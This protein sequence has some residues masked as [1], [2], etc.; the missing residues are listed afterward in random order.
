[1]SGLYTPVDNMPHWAQVLSYFSPLKYVIQVF[2]MIYLKG[3]GFLDMIPRFLAL[4]GFAVFFNAWAV[5]SYRKT[6]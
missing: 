1:M 6:E 3:S 5:Y 2:R 4:C